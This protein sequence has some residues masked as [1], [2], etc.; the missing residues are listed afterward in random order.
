[1]LSSLEENSIKVKKTL[2]L[3]RF[4]PQL[5]ACAGVSIGWVASIFALNLVAPICNL[6]WE[7]NVARAQLWHLFSLPG[8]KTGL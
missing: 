6:G 1:M 2:Y 8:F 7:L 4:W 3:Y 5:H